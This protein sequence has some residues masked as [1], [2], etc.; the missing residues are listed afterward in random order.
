MKFFRS[1]EALGF[2]YADSRFQGFKYFKTAQERKS[3][4]R[5]SKKDKKQKKVKHKLECQ[6]QEEFTEY[7]KA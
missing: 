2:I 5:I 1:I 7:S 3:R 4:E 6:V